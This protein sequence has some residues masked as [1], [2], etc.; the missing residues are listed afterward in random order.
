MEAKA[1]SQEEDHTGSP[2]IEIKD[3]TLA[4]EGRV[5]IEGFSLL[6]SSGERVVLKGPSGAGKTS[7]LRSILGFTVPAKGYIAVRGQQIRPETIWDL[8]TQIGYVP[9]EPEP[10]NGTVEEWLERPFTYKANRSLRSNLERIPELFRHFLLPMELLEK[11]VQVLS[12]GEKQRMAIV[13]AILLNRPIMLLDEPTSA[14][15]D[16]SKRRLIEFLASQEDLTALVVSH[17]PDLRAL[18]HRVVTLN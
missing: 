9:Q 16:L 1:V 5:L 8:R 18:A 6:V 4:F 12:G 2:A 10:G 13:S 14:L 7:L 17:D 15:D 3:L 11:E